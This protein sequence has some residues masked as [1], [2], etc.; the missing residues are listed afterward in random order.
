MAGIKKP[1][2]AVW[3]KRVSDVLYIVGRFSWI[4]IA[5]AI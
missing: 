3:L 2:K 5:P 4:Y 1:A